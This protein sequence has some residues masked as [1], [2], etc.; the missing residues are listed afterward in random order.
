MVIREFTFDYFIG[1]LKEEMDR[2]DELLYHIGE[3]PEDFTEDEK[4]KRVLEIV[5]ISIVNTRMKFYCVHFLIA[6]L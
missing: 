3:N 2:V 1:K 4:I 5:Y 6:N